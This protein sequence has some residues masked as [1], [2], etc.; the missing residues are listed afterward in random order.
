[1][2]TVF[3]CIFGSHLSGTTTQESDVDYKSIRI[4]TAREILLG[5][6]KKSDKINARPKEERE[7]NQ[8]GEHDE[9]AFSL[10]KYLDMLASGQTGAI[11]MLFAPDNMVLESSELWEYIKER[12]S[13][14]LTKES[15]AFVGYC[16]QQAAKYGA[17]A[18]R[19]EAAR[20]ASETFTSAIAFWGNTAKVVQLEEVLH[21][22]SSTSE[23]MQIVTKETQPGR[24]ETYFECCNRMVGFKNT[25]KEAAA[26]Y[27]R[28]Y[29]GYGERAR[30]AEKSD[31]IDWKAVSHAVRVGYEA[32]EL[33][34]TSHV[35]FPLPNADY[36]R[37]IKMGQLPFKPIAEEIEQ[38][39]IDVEAAALTS[40]LREKADYDFIDNIVAREY[41]S[42]VINDALHGMTKITLSQAA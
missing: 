14:F 27:Q 29:D 18:D 19:M 2:Q 8:A 6:V 33:L 13:R 17:K 40:K 36:I 1:M 38:L 11:D 34:A 41:R 28:V 5:K 35:T 20:V 23:H 16:R 31:G 9:E 26:M 21:S 24:Y 32:I 3:R 7:K 10:D 4:P 30:K 25:L 12:R 22:I 37:A 42:A 39:L 15:A